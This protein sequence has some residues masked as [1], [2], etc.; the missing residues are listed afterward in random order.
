MGSRA[1]FTLCRIQNKE[2]FSYY[3]MFRNPISGKR[4]TKKSI[5][6]LKAS[7]NM[8]YEV[9]NRRDEAIIIAQRALESNII[10]SHNKKL[11]FSTFLLDFYDL[12]KSEYFKRKLM[13]DPHAISIDYVS[14]RRN[15]IQNHII[16]LISKE[17]ELVKVDLNFL[18]TIQTDLVNRDNLSSTTVNQIM[19]SISL[20]LEYAKKKNYITHSVTT[21]V[22]TINI[23][24]KTRGIL[25]QEETFTFMKYIKKLKNKRVF[26]SC[27]LSLVTGMRSGELRALK[28]NNL[29]D[30]LIKIDTAYANL[31]G[32]KEPK[33]KKSRIVPCPNSLIEDLKAFAL[34][35]PY[36]DKIEGLVFWSARGGKVVSSHYFCSKFKEALIDSKVLNKEEIE[37]RNISFHSLR[38]MANT[39]LRGSVD[40]YILRLTIGHSSDQLSDIYSHIEENALK[41]LRAA[42]KQN[43][44]PLISLD[45]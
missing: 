37:E 18:E 26:L 17:F 33:G 13:L 34:S 23:K 28:I 31:A 24:G 30:N 41:S 1:P 9:V 39:L 2:K 19:S 3:V 5:D 42:Q 7:L 6:K 45:E 10:F 21:K 27:Y 35:N 20:A 14:I 22:D 12:E 4:C 38:H 36:E 8:G 15:L 43:I 32:F 11:T 40:E 29:Q 16:P 44:L 25:S